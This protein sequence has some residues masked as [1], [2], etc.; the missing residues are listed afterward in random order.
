[1]KKF[2]LILLIT[3]L[4]SVSFAQEQKGFEVISPAEYQ[5]QIRSEQIHLIDVRTPEEFA[6]SHIEGAKNINFH[7]NDFLAQFS[8]L[9]REKPVYLY[10]K[11][12]N[13]SGKAAKELADMGFTKIVDLKGGFLA[14]KE[15]VKE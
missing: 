6:E 11:S 2:F 15:F 5:E 9:E 14:W 3:M 10:C 8:Q 12:G 13:R 4:T 7:S 1:M